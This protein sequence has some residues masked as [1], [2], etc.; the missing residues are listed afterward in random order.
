MNI[1]ANIPLDI[2]AVR[3]RFPGLDRGWTYFDNAGGSQILG[4][5]VERISEFLLTRNVQIGGSYETSLK[6]AEALRESREAARLFVN[7]QRSEEIVFGGSTTVLLNLLAAS[8]LGQLSEGDEIIVTGADHES[9]IGPWMRL[10]D[11]GIIIKTWPVNQDSWTLEPDQLDGLLSDRTRLVCVTHVSNVLGQINPI[12]E[13][14]D[15]VHGANARLC[16]DGVA[17]APH[18]AIDVQALDV[19]YYVFSLYKV[20]GPH[21]AIMYG[22]YDNLR[23]LDGQYHYFYDRDVV[24]GKLEPGNANYELSWTVPALTNYICE[25]GGGAD[26]SAL[27]RGF[28]AM[29]THERRLSDRL[30]SYLRGRNDCTI[31]GNS[32]AQAEDR[33]AT[34]SF[35][36]DGLASGAVCRAVDPHKIAI[37]HGDFHARRLI[38]NLNLDGGVVRVSMVHYNTLEEVDALI[39]AIDAIR[40]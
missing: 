20:Y 4:T 30:L 36:L 28:S 22:K 13:I 38:E 17:F 10:R 12:R 5:A 32:N 25:L 40:A 8:M 31:Y 26:R 34:I 1:S 14:A 39:T 27:E 19:D 2:E 9:N 33:V 15:K 21:H 16:V 6:A 18:N 24:P 29:A 3:S 35:R 11:R 37:R 7:A 23:E